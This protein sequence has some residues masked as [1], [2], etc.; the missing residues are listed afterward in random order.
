MWREAGWG[1]VYE[2]DDLEMGIVVAV[3]ILRPEIFGGAGLLA[4][5]K[6]EVDLARRVSHPN[7]ARI[8]DIGHRTLPDGRDI[9]F[10]TMEFLEGE[11]LAP[12]YFP[13]GPD[14]GERSV[15][16]DSGAWCGRWTPFTRTGSCIGILRARM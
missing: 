7:I 11:T 1:E 10:L 13:G 14:S 9:P 16:A 12:A 2:A 15:A 4:R 8:H 5:F 3:K 6:R